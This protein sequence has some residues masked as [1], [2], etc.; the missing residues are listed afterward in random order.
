MLHWNGTTIKEIHKLVILGCVRCRI[1]AKKTVELKM[2]NQPKARTTVAPCCYACMMDI[3][4]GL[5]GQA[6]KRARTVMKFM[7]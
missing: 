7:D 1:I 3:C 2:A 4:Y 6:Y 5:K